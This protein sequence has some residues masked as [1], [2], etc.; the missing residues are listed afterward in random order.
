MGGIVM[1]DKL[2]ESNSAEADFKARRKFFMMSFVVVG[3][4]FV[5]ALMIDLYAQE[6]NLGT[7]EFELAAIIAP[8]MPEA[9]EPK[10]PRQP[11]TQ[12]SSEPKSDVPVRNQLIDRIADSTKIP[13]SVS[14]TPSKFREIP[15][16]PFK[17][18][19]GPETDGIGSDRSFN[20]TGTT[21][22]GT[23]EPV[24]TEIVKTPPPPAIV[25]PEPKKVVTQ[26]KGVVNG[27]AIDLPK[28]RYSPAAQA[29]RLTGR[30]NVQVA[31]DESGNV[32]SAKAI[33]GHMLFARDA[34][35]AARRAKFKPTYLGDQPVKV[36]G[37]IVY[38]FTR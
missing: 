9:P 35:Q 1:F 17:L 34:E 24:E 12:S 30:V 22:A 29:I 19:D 5:S 8:V 33:D 4:L 32:V 25:K 26:S 10:Q 16:G 7:E 15:P 37:V 13:D 20:E 28:P 14:T 21:S 23:A 31:I 11:Q 38:N 2:I 6:L 18:S 3:I 36:T 27:F